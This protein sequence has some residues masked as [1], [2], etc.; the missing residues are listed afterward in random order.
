MVLSSWPIATARVHPVHLDECRSA[1][2]A[3]ADPPTKPTDLGVESVCI[4]LRHDLHPPSPIDSIRHSVL[5]VEG[6]GGGKL[7]VVSLRVE[8]L[9]TLRVTG[10]LICPKLY[11]DRVDVAESLAKIKV[12]HGIVPL[13]RI[14]MLCMT[15]PCHALFGSWCHQLV[16]SEYVTHCW[17]LIL[18]HRKRL[19][20]V[21]VWR[22]AVFVCTFTMHRH[23]TIFMYTLHTWIMILQA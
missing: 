8:S 13:M 16:Y 20:D 14:P 12:A 21:M 2:R 11:P 17:K 23:T 4:W 10:T 3:A 9:A 22:A 1:R 15:C 6:K 7:P 18:C 5:G 19:R